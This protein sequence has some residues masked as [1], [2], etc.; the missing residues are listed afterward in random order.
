MCPAGPS[1]RLETMGSWI[2]LCARVLD[3]NA[4]GRTDNEEPKYLR[5]CVLG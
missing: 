3:V 5:A 1:V 2:A 4:T